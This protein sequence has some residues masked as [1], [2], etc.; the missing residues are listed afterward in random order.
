MYTASSRTNIQ[1]SKQGIKLL[2]LWLGICVLAKNFR[3]PWLCR[4]VALFTRS[5][6][7]VTLSVY[8]IIIGN[9]GW[10][11]CGTTTC[12]TQWGVKQYSV[13]STAM[14]I[15]CECTYLSS[16]Q[17]ALQCYSVPGTTNTQWELLIDI[18]LVHVLL[19]RF[20]P[21]FILILSRFLSRFF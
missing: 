17:C 8:N 3:E 6:R 9:R 20:Y 16:A 12:A 2:P 18:R 10:L 15:I 4:N 5:N 19:S 13:I 21:D 14:T 1:I 11:E 7:N